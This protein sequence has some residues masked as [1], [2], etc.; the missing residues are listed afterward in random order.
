LGLAA[1]SLSRGGGPDGRN[2]RARNSAVK[3]HLPVSYVTR[4]K[5]C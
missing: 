3:L 5:R 2:D 1:G 4:E